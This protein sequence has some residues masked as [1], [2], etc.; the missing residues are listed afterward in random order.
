MSQQAALEIQRSV[1]QRMSA[2]QQRK[3]KWESMQAQA[4]QAS[5]AHDQQ[6]A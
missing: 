3:Q 4:A 5:A 6:I 1:N 2:A